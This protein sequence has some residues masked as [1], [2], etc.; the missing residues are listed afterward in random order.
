MLQKKLETILLNRFQEARLA[1]FYLLRCPLFTSSPEE[2]LE[3]WIRNLLTLLLGHHRQLSKEEASQSLLQGHPDILFVHKRPDKSHYV[4]NKQENDF[5]DFLKFLPFKP[6]EFPQKF[7]IVSKAHLI[8]KDQWHKLLKALEDIPKN[9][10]LF[11]LYPSQKEL[12]PT[13]KSRCLELTLPLPEETREKVSSEKN[14]KFYRPEDMSSWLKDH[15]HWKES[16]EDVAK[17]NRPM[18]PEELRESL[19]HFLATKTG[20]NQILDHLKNDERG[21]Q[22]LL[23]ALLTWET[24]RA[25]CFNE[26]RRAL[27]EIKWHF[28]SKTFRNPSSERLYSLLWAFQPKTP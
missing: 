4:W 27:E 17:D 25:G 15:I 6:F 23:S 7:I 20:E 22:E 11:F 5:R 12:L 18:L 28:L 10:T 21:Q 3:E 1:G 14:T 19:T 13:I 16:E 2:F 26:K 8:Q 24:R 9:T